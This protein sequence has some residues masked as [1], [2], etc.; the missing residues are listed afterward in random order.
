M[1]L[2]ACPNCGRSVLSYGRYL[3]EPLHTRDYRCVECKSELCLKNRIL[4]NA[5][6][7]VLLVFAV[8]LAFR[9]DSDSGKTIPLWLAVILLL[10]FALL[11]KTIFYFFISWQVKDFASES[12]GH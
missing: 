8:L 1:S 11:V 10:V 6:S 3:L 9:N 12:R 7:L 4:L 2:R 5:V